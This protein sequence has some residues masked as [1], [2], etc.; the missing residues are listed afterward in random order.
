MFQLFSQWVLA[1]IILLTQVVNPTSG[2]QATMCAVPEHLQR[3]IVHELVHSLA[4]RNL[5]VLYFS[6]D[7]RL[8]LTV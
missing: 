6:P 5:K 7:E 2:I 8:S 4:K 3:A 1:F